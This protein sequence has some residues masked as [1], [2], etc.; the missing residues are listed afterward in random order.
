MQCIKGLLILVT[1]VFAA[2]LAFAVDPI[3]KES[4]FSGHIGPGIGAV[5]YKGNMIAGL[6][7]I[8]TDFGEATTKTLTGEAESNTQGIGLLNFEIGYNFASTRTR[9]FLGSSLEDFLQFDLAQQLGVRQEIG[10]LG[11]VSAG[12]LISNI[13]ITVWKDPYATNVVRQDTDRESTGGRFIWGKIL[14]TGLQIQLDFRNIDI[15][16]EQSGTSLG[17]TAAQRQQLDR[18]GDAFR[19]QLQYR[20]KITPK[21][22]LA[23][24]FSYRTIDSDG[25]AMSSDTYDFQ[26]TYLYIGETINFAANAL[27]GKAD[28]DAANPIPV[29]NNQTQE[30]DRYGGTAT[31]FYKNPFDWEWF[32][33]DK[34]SFYGTVAYFVADSNIDFYTTELTMGVL[35]IMYRF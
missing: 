29:F 9:V 14:N 16:E 20:F 27:F 12:F 31:L 6:S 24:A 4:G 23:P 19:G 7:K 5:K 26:L 35:G 18:N 15:D 1:V 30:D 33:S 25:D 11:I 32:G 2:N 13:P 3:P 34:I 17:L 10:N 8:N 28:Y 22:R 21:H